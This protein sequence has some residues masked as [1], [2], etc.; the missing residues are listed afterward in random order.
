MS[1]TQAIPILDLS[2]EIQS[3]WPQLTDAVTRVMKSGQFILGPEVGAF[4][5]EAAKYL[6]VKHAIGC[7]SGTDAL[8]IALRALGVKPGDEVITTPFTYIAP[9][10]SIHQMGARVIFADV[11]PRTFLIDPLDVARKLTPRTRAIIPVHLFGQ[12]APEFV[13]LGAQGIVTAEDAAAIA[14]GLDR[15]AAE[16]EA[17]GV[18]ENWDLEDI[19]MTTESRL[20]EL[21]GPAAGRLP[22]DARPGPRRPG[23]R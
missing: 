3:L 20:A 10:E 18:P 4:E 9:A 22:A 13:R 8:V 19:H 21:I 17:S 5:A 12:A 2:G 11:D 6:G 1:Q 23:A 7:N 15:I 14:D 16:Y